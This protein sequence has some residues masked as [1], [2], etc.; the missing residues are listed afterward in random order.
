[1]NNNLLNLIRPDLRDF[2]PYSSARDEAK[3][4][5]IWLNANELPWDDCLDG[6]IKVNRYPEKQ[7]AKLL[8]MLA[9]V[10]QVSANQ[11]ALLRGS[12]EAIDLLTRLLCSAGKD[13]VIVCPPTFDM[14]ATCA[15]LQGAAVIEVPLIKDYGF[16]LDVASIVN[17]WKPNIKIIYLCSPNNPSGNV[18]NKN[19]ILSICEK[20]LGKCIVVVDEAYIEFSDSSSLTSSI[21]EYT[22]LVI[23]RTL[24]KAYGLAGARCGFLIAEAELIN[25]IRKIMP[26]YPISSLSADAVRQIFLPAE[27][28][29]IQ[30]YIT[31][32]KSERARIF[33]QLKKLSLVKKIWPS[34]ANF[35]LI[36]VDSAETVM[37]KCAEQGMILRHMSNKLGLKNA[38]RITIGKPEEND[39]LLNKLSDM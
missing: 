27:L 39:L 2:N 1:M 29:K 35:I 23:L 9:N 32:I 4:G 16:Q 18:M 36:E 6:S 31:C 10:Y 15:R 11:M 13:A 3:S 30:N 20:L 7:P 19:D 25:W 37:G 33:Q 14:Y 12:D 8:N 17:L 21:N 38:I 26:P 22:N 5:N 28:N 24:S 34:D